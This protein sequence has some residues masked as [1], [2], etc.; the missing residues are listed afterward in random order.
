MD[1]TS[2]MFCVQLP[3]HARKGADPSS[4][5]PRHPLGYRAP[6]LEQGAAF[7]AQRSLHVKETGPYA[8]Q[9][10]KAGVTTKKLAQESANLEQRLTWLVVMPD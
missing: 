4:M 10:V 5:Q 1:M 3:K 6:S 8:N 9:Q 7:A 2:V